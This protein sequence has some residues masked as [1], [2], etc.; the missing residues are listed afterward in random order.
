M[1]EQIELGDEVIDIYTGFK[2]HARKTK[3]RSVICCVCNNKY[4]TLERYY[5]RKKKINQKF[6]CSKRCVGLNSVKYFI[7]KSKLKYDPLIKKCLKK[8]M[9]GYAIS[10][11]YGLN[12]KTV[13]NHIKAFV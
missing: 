4:V 8:G 11:K 7:N 9:T 1:E 2:L 3:F 10:K 5:K 6:M 12:R 13:Y